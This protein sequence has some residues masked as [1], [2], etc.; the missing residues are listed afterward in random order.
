M[1]RLFLFT[2]FFSVILSASVQSFDFAT[3]HT[4][5][6]NNLELITENMRQLQGLYN[7]LTMIKNQVEELKAVANYKNSLGAIDALRN[8]LT[9][10]TRQGEVLSKETDGILAQLGPWQNN[11]P[12]NES[13]WS[14]HHEAI[15][16]PLWQIVQNTVGRVKQIRQLYAGQI[17]SANLLMA[18]NNQAVGQTQALQTSNE[19]SAQNLVQTQST[20]ELLS[21]QTLLK[22]SL[23]AAQLQKEKEDLRRGKE[24]D[25]KLNEFFNDEAPTGGARDIFNQIISQ[26]TTRINRIQ[27][28]SI[29]LGKELFYPLALIS[30]ALIGL[31]HLLRKH[32][33]MTDAN[34]ELIRWL[35]YLNCFY[36]FIA[37]YSQITVFVFKS[38]GE[39]GGYL[40]I[41]A[42]GGQP[43][44]LD[45][46]H[47]INVGLRC[48]KKI[49]SVH[50]QFDF[51]GLR[52]FMDI[53]RIIPAIFKLMVVSLI[54]LGLAVGVL[55]CFVSISMELIL[56]QIGSQV[57]FAGGV[58]LL[59]FSS[60]HWIRDYAERYVHTFFQVGIK[61]VFIYIMIGL[62][63]GF[64]NQWP[65]ILGKAYDHAFPG[66]VVLD[67]H[68]ILFLDE[69]LA[70]MIAAFI[71]WRLCVK[72]PDHAVSYLTGRLPTSF[73]AGTSVGA[74]FRG[75]GSAIKKG[76]K[77]INAARAVHGLNKQGYRLAQDAAR[78]S[79]VQYF[80]KQNKL[81]TEQEFNAHVI[82]TLGE[83]KRQV[84]EAA[85]NKKLDETPGGKMAQEILKNSG[86]TTKESS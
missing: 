41:K 5:I 66:S 55:F 26:Y 24:I 77:E 83:A 81:P 21:E 39:I 1:M 56:V 43:V 82:K 6:L 65:Q 25:A 22:A 62:G 49:M 20:Q 85:L 29:S 64:A 42:S 73:D 80:Q 63:M 58:F 45:P 35:F 3:E 50:A 10:I 33:S 2:L 59:A 48:F 72:V 37:N 30:V 23:M 76:V 31:N 7:Q 51:L 60:L 18:L 84:R 61:M 69:A 47:V 36:A 16:R 15:N 38:I 11:P 78:Q 75:T 19:L 12:H 70:V 28:G 14:S 86:T 17:A 57:I 71:Y 67:W 34:I 4:Q 79:T 68:P 27:A 44:D 54:C 13:V 46:G 32:V 74:L 40:G 9:D 8:E 52:H 53:T